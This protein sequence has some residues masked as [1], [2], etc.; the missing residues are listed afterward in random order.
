MLI[1]CTLQVD[2][3]NETTEAVLS[4][5]KDSGH[6]YFL[7]VD[8]AY[9]P[10]LHKD[11]D[12]P[13][14][15]EKMK[16]TNS[17]M[18]PYQQRLIDE[19]G[20]SFECEKLVPNLMNKS[21]YVLHYRNLQLYLSLGM[22]LVKVHKVLAFHQTAWM[23]PYIEKNTHLRTTATNEFE[24]DFYKFMNNAVSH[25]WISLYSL[26]QISAEFVKCPARLLLDWVS[27][28]C[29]GF[30]EDYGERQ[31]TRECEDTAD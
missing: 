29:S 7:E 24:K 25:S 20:T 16:V 3:S 28:F 30:R 6:G 18:S 11:H 31:E 23:Q 15:P 14:A 21:R 27:F 5:S 17:M 13:L 9:P 2:P 12:Y 19:L 10:E 26:F 22:K 1:D 8:L 4:T